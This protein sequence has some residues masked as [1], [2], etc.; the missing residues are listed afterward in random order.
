M[1]IVPTAF[2]SR[3]PASIA[4]GVMAGL[5]VTTSAATAGS[6]IAPRPYDLGVRVVA[7]TTSGASTALADDLRAV[8][9]DE[10]AARACYRSVR[11]V[12]DDRRETGQ[13]LLKV[14]IDEIENLTE[15]DVSLARRELSDQPADRS[16]FRMEFRL[17]AEA[18]LLTVGSDA[19]ILSKPYRV[20]IVER[21]R[22]VG[23]D[24]APEVRARLLDDFADRVAGI[25]CKPDPRRLDRWVREV[26]T[27]TDAAR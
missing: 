20:R 22:F 24:P 17:V 26:S 12:D 18:G 9:V 6:T 15:H 13:L 23:H 7:T 19:A 25:A 10:L 16:R 3:G 4:L 11:A 1:S 2:R 8:L 5:A 14:R 27:A 21:P